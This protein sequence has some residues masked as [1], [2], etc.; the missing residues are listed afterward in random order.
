MKTFLVTGGAG[1]IGSNFVL[2]ERGRGDVR[3]INLDL[4]IYAGNLSASS[5]IS[6]VRKNQINRSG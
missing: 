4:L 1:F 2:A 6:V 3:I 5:A